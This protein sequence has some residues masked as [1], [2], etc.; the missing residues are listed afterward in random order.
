MSRASGK[1]KT[2]GAIINGTKTFIVGRNTYSNASLHPGPT[3]KKLYPS[4]RETLIIEQH[5]ALRLLVALVKAPPPS[6]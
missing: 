5:V 4:S 3:G 1:I 2:R 6:P